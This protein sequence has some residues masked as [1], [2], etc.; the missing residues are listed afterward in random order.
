M[1]DLLKKLEAIEKEQKEQKKQLAIHKV[2]IEK[3]TTHQEREM[4]AKRKRDRANFAKYKSAIRQGSK[5][6]KLEGSPY[7]HNT[8]CEESS[9]D[10]FLLFAKNTRY[11]I[12]GVKIFPDRSLAERNKRQLKIQQN[13]DLLLERLLK[14]RNMGLSDLQNEDNQ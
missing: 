14:K 8:F 1:A 6:C 10:V 11:M 4:S 12:D 2:E 13:E 5:A 7:R 3:M 9:R